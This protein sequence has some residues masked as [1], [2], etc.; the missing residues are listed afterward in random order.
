[1]SFVKRSTRR[2]AE[3]G[4][5]VKRK[6]AARAWQCNCKSTHRLRRVRTGI[7]DRGCVLA[8]AALGGRSSLRLSGPPFARLRR[9]RRHDSRKEK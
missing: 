2:V 9:S 3:F 6:L 1:V 7:V 8:L 5:L 4:S